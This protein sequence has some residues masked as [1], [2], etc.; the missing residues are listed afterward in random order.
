MARKITPELLSQ[1]KGAVDILEVVGEH[2]VLRKAGREYQGLCPFHNERSGSFYVNSEKQLYHCHGCNASGDIVRF[3]QEIHGLSFAEA[4]RELAERGR[5]ALPREAASALDA[6]GTPEEIK[7]REARL[8]KTALATKLNRFVAEFYFQKLKHTPQALA[9]LTQR[10]VNSDWIRQFYVGYSSKDWD[11]LGRFLAEK[12]AP[13]PLA[14]ELGLIRKSTRQALR[15]GD[16]G[17]FDLFRNRIIFPILDTRGRVVGFG[18]RTL[19]GGD[20]AADPSA[21]KYLNSTESILFKK[22]KVAYGLFQ[23]QK[24]IR[25]RDEVVFVEGYFDVIALHAAGFG[26]AVATCGTS[27]T[28]DH[29]QLL[30]RFGKKFTLLFDADKAGEAATLRAMELGLE[31]GLVF[32]GASM[33]SGLDPDE[34]LFDPKTGVAVPE[35]RRQME[36]ILQ[37][38]EPLL[39]ACIAQAL[40]PQALARAEDK[41]AGLKQVAVWLKKFS[42]EVGRAV[43]IEALRTQYGVSDDLLGR[44]GLGNSKGTAAPVSA[45]PVQIYSQEPPLSEPFFASFA[46]SSAPVYPRKERKWDGARNSKDWGSDRKPRAPLPPGAA[47]PIARRPSQQKG[48]LSDREKILLQGLAIGGEYA[49]ILRSSRQELPEGMTL[50]HFFDYLPAQ[51]WV[52]QL[53][54]EPE[55]MDRFRNAPGAVLDPNLDRQV[56]STLTEVWVQGGQVSG[57]SEPGPS[58]EEFQVAVRRSLGK[59]WAR[60]SQTLKSALAVAEAKKDAGLE[61]KLMKDYLDVQRKLKEFST[62]YDEA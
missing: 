24:H 23:A 62:F 14:E 1:I 32:H 35:G 41:A 46:E 39:D 3:V 33:P 38:A 20:D 10:G 36:A 25:E 5:V 26:H 4:V 7:A 9:Y 59:V 61:T 13:L 8:E 31:H 28:A 29:L 47:G 17:H 60:F 12:K 42:D 22:S 50:A 37:K 18:G 48:R 51:E 16:A 43:R 56:L 58:Q 30:Q 49:N 45:Q 40:S 27:L 15:P 11:S 6:G 44:L 34:V 21:P 2:V 53:E 55:F 57:R 54:R 19:P 52:A